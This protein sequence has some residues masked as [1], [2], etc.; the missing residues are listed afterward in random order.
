MPRDLFINTHSLNQR[1]EL[2]AVN[3]G[4]ADA[5]RAN[6]EYA[7]DLARAELWQL[8]AAA[9]Q[10]RCDRIMASFPLRSLA[11]IDPAAVIGASFSANQVFEF[12]EQSEPL[13]T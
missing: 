8:E 3:A 9:W 12:E 2:A 5:R 1:L 11:Q 13:L 7:G 4:R 10:S 6:A